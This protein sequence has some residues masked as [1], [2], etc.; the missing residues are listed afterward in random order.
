MIAETGQHFMLYS[1]LLRGGH[2]AEVL[3]SALGTTELALDLMADPA[4]LAVIFGGEDDSLRRVMAGSP[5][6]ETALLRYLALAGLTVGETVRETVE[7]PV[8]WGGVLQNANCTRLVFHS[9]AYLALNREARFTIAKLPTNPSRWTAYRGEAWLYFYDGSSVYRAPRVDPT[10][11]ERVGNLPYPCGGAVLFVGEKFLYLYGSGSGNFATRIMRA[12][13]DD[14]A[15]F[16]WMED[17]VL[18]YAFSYGTCYADSGFVYLF[19]GGNDTKIMRA[20]LGTPDVFTVVE[21]RRLPYS[22]NGAALVETSTEIYLLGGYNR[23]M[24]AAKSDPTVFEQ[25]TETL[26]ADIGQFAAYVGAGSVYLYGGGSDYTGIYSAPRSRPVSFT[27]RGTLP[28]K[29]RLATV[30]DAGDRVWLLGSGDPEYYNSAMSAPTESPE[31][32]EVET[33]RLE[34][35]FLNG[36]LLAFG[37]TMYYYPKDSND[38]YSAPRN[39]PWRMNKSG[40]TMRG[41]FGAYLR[42]LRVPGGWLFFGRRVSKDGATCLYKVSESDPFSFSQLKDVSISAGSV[43]VCAVYETENRF[44]FYKGTNISVMLKDPFAPLLSLNG[45]QFLPCGVQ[46]SAP[47]YWDERYIYI[48]GVPTSTVA[49]TPPAIG[50]LRAEA[51][52]PTVFTELYQ[53]LPVALPANSRLL[54]DLKFIYLI[55]PEVEGSDNTKQYCVL[56]ADKSRPEVFEILADGLPADFK[57]A[58]VY[59]DGRRAVLLQGVNVAAA[60]LI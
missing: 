54:T 51:D 7:D 48:Y 29:S 25:L 43:D 46:D 38:I 60:N 57:G 59:Y 4:A 20:P 26:P 50:I 18:P 35:A 24:C 6:E 28:L 1:T 58:A 42:A 12:P 40:K 37:E 33:G 52:N 27:M 47:L 53:L 11:I 34:R 15:A 30:A 23:I 8:L 9:A 16:T 36:V 13:L 56:R 22:C 32:M 49:S 55:G 19:G 39:R 44:Y 10:A 45:S 2:G 5:L 41:G 31:L 21:G 3:R 14:P 17:K